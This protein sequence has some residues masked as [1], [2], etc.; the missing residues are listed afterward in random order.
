MRSHEGRAVT[1]ANVGGISGTVKRG[2]V[3]SRAV[4]VKALALPLGV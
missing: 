1:R 2:R 4:D 3:A